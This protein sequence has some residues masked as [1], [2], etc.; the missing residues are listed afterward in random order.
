[1][2][3]VDAVVEDGGFAKDQIFRTNL[4]ILFGIL[5]AI[6]PSEIADACTISKM[7]HH[8]FLTRSHGE[9]LKTKD[10][11]RHLNK[12]HL[13]RQFVDGVY[14]RTIYIFIRIILEQITIGFNAEFV[15]QHLLTIGSHSWQELD[16][17]LQYVHPLYQHL[18]NFEVVGRGDLDILT[19]SF[20]EGDGMTIRLHH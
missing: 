2:G 11:A 14:L 6:K 3:E 18:G 19:I 1:M 13:A 9:R 10:T 20:D 12:G 8:T 7:G 5:S 15:T 17:L 4:I 16:V